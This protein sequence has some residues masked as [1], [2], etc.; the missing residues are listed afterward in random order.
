MRSRFVLAAL[1]LLLLG[2]ALPAAAAVVGSFNALNGANNATGQLGI[3]GFALDSAGHVRAVDLRVDGIVIMRMVYGLTRP[4]TTRNFPGYPD[5]AAPGFSGFLDTTRFLN[6]RHT[7]SVVVTAADRSQTILPV[8]RVVNV[9]NAE[10][11][12]PPF[13]EITFPHPD[14]ALVGTC[15]PAA[16]TRRLSVFTGNVLDAGVQAHDTGVAFVELLIDGSHWLNSV[17]DC[18]FFT[19]PFV[20]TNTKLQCYGLPSRQ[21]TFVYPTLPNSDRAKFRFALDIGALLTGLSSPPFS[22]AFP[23]GVYAPGH[24]T[25]TI[26]AGDKGDNVIN[27]ATINVTFDCDSLELENAIGQIEQPFPFEPAFGNGVSLSGNVKV[28]G[29]AI[30]PQGINHIDVK[31]DGLLAGTATLGSTRL[32]K[33][34]LYLGIDPATSRDFTF[35]LDTTTLPDDR[36]TVEIWVVDNNGVE[37]LV[38]ESSVTIDNHDNT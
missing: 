9:H 10:H 1:T 28:H 23:A 19:G 16:T 32:D 22:Q 36:V 7:L 27:V 11:M 17:R 15:D 8:S 31:V 35:T 20:P 6:G 25:I 29:W 14:A 33:Q 38:G 34:E 3:T 5:S 21:L 37:T 4:S 13:G 2:G 30:D 26:R 12:D 18:G 24:H